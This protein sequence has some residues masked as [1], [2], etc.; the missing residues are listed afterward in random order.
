MGVYDTINYYPV[1][2]CFFLHFA[3]FLLSHSDKDTLSPMLLFGLRFS[4]F[5]GGQYTTAILLSSLNMM[6][7]ATSGRENFA[8]S[9]SITYI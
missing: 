8:P 6:Y 1:Q 3:G 7:F 4:H 2:L 5:D 9:R